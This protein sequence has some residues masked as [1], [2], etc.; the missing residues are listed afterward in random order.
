[1]TGSGS[2]GLAVTDG[3]GGYRRPGNPAPASGPGALSQRTDGGPGQKL[4]AP[5]GMEYGG[6]KTLLDQE[7]TSPMYAQPSPGDRKVQVPAGQP[8]QGGGQG[9]QLT[10]L[11]APTQNPDEPVTAGAAIGPGPNAL[12]FTA[13]PG[14]PQQ[15]PVTQMLADLSARD[16]TGVL[17]NL[18]QSALAAGA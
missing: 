1:M 4:S 14:P 10:P 6:Q 18:Y 3:H 16:R 17:A 13:P 11:D 9:P 5:T 7:R 2:A 8:Q 15:G 12:P